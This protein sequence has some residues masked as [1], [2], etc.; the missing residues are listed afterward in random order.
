[1]KEKIYK[2]LYEHYKSLYIKILYRAQ[3][4]INYPGTNKAEGD[5]EF[6]NIVVEPEKY[7]YY[8]LVSEKD[9]AIIKVLEDLL[10][11]DK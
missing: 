1:M 6:V 10:K 8:G 9:A 3:N 4:R 2:Q 11:E 5:H 7:D